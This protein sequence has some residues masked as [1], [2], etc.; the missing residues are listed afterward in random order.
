MF[1]A[2]IMTRLK[3]DWA[4]SK[5]HH[6]IELERE[7]MIGF[8]DK[9]NIDTQFKRNCR[10]PLLPL[11]LLEPTFIPSSV[12]TAMVVSMCSGLTIAVVGIIAGMF[13]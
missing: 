9:H 10:D 8:A 1:H 11:L 6:E 2:D 5:V 7:K 12:I 13:F 4:L 3:I